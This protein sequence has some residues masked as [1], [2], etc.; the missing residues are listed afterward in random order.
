MTTDKFNAFQ[1]HKV[2]REV[3]SEHIQKWF[4]END[5]LL[6]LE[7]IINQ[8]FLLNESKTGKQVHLNRSS[9]HAMQN[10]PSPYDFR[11]IEI[12][13]YLFKHFHNLYKLKKSSKDNRQE[14][15]L[16]DGDCNEKPFLGFYKNGK[17]IE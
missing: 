7:E 6:P 9:W 17:E 15:V 12:N 4:D 11:L 10:A 14:L 5:K 1:F 16:F 2:R 3:I 8:H 13:R